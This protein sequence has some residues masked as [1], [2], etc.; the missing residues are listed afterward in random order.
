[1]P[2]AYLSNGQIADQL[3]AEL[4]VVAAMR[5]AGVRDL[6]LRAADLSPE[7]LKPIALMVEQTRRLARLEQGEDDKPSAAIVVRP[8]GPRGRA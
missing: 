3:G 5:K 4:H 2:P 7:S 1:M 8:A 6:A